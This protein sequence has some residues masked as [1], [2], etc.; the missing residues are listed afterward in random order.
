M[1]VSLVFET[2]EF[3]WIQKAKMTCIIPEEDGKL[4]A[5]FFRLYLFKWKM[6][7]FKPQSCLDVKI[8]QAGE[9]LWPL[10]LF[11]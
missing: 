9:E 8:G 1:Y 4:S 11:M 5:V 10:S 3:C 6:Y 2:R 7:P